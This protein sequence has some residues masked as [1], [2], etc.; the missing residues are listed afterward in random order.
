MAEDLTPQQL[1]EDLVAAYAIPEAPPGAFTAA[2]FAA[3]TGRPDS[4]ARA[5][6]LKL[7]REGKI[8]RL[9]IDGE[10]KYYYD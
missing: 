10:Y 6:L 5:I 3:R 4:G 8:K 9:L 7:Y 2:T 1:Y